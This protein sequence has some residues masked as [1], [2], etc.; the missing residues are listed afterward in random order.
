MRRKRVAKRYRYKYRNNRIKPRVGRKLVLAAAA[1]VTAVAV[2]GASLWNL[3]ESAAPVEA[4][5]SFG[6]IGKVVDS[7]SEGEPFVILD[8]VPGTASYTYTSLDG[9]ETF[10]IPNISLGTMG[11]LTNGQTPLE[12]SLQAAF[13]D[14]QDLFGD[15]E[16]RKALAAALMPAGM[17]TSLLKL[18]YREGYAGISPDL[19]AENGWIQI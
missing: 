19:S 7:H 14:H 18:D 6:G 3:M 5:E 13:N 15:Y 2:A 10:E 12:E 17:D 8:I 4:K 11:Y 9:S 16:E 1:S